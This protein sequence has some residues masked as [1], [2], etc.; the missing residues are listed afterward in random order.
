M[1]GLHSVST[2]LPTLLAGWLMLAAGFGKKRIER[3]PRRRK[4]PRPKPR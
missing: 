3:R 4:P 2:I 1:T